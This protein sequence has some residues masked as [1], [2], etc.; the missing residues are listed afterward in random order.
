LMLLTFV[1]LTHIGMTPL[2]LTVLVIGRDAAI[3]LGVTL[4]KLFGLRVQI[5]PLPIGKISTI[6]QVGYVALI[7]VFLTFAIDSPSSVEA[8]G[9]LTAAATIISWLVYGQLLLRG[10]LPGSRTA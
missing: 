2:W 4:V 6:I 9:V 8:L 3:V 7:L 1:S 5:E 10:L